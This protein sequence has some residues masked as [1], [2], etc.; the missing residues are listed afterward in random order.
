LWIKPVQLGKDRRHDIEAAVMEAKALFPA[1][2]PK[3]AGAIYKSLMIVFP[4]V[5]A[6]EAAELVDSVKEQ[7]KPAFVQ[8]GLMLGEFHENNSMPGLH[9]PD[10]FPLRSPLPMLVIRAMVPSDLI[11]LNRPDELPARRALFLRS[12][13][14]HQRAVP[15]KERQRLEA[16]I[17][18]LE[19]PSNLTANGR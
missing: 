1:I 12:F 9:N 15:G 5:T 14:Q 7:L 4:D 13:L 16:L 8:D 3:R 2:E 19:A 6:A 17:L 18:T 10:F 11:F